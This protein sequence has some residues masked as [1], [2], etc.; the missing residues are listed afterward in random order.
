MKAETEYRL[1]PMVRHSK[2][3]I[4]IGLTYPSTDLIRPYAPDTR[5]MASGKK[6]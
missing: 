5:V 2:N 4:P 6:K 1:M 3:R